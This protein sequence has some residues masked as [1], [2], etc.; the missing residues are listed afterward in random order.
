MVSTVHLVVVRTVSME[1]VTINLA[2]VYN[3]YLATLEFRAIKNV[4]REHSDHNVSQIALKPAL[5]HVISVMVV[6]TAKQITKA[7]CAQSALMDCLD[8]T[9][10]S[11]AQIFVTEN[12]VIYLQENVCPAWEIV[13]DLSVKVEYYN[14]HRSR[15]D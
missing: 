4:S 2:S 10:A 5:M 6:A 13:V 3:V 1:Y 8:R 15:S 9:V 7:N 11:L 14:P 12:Y